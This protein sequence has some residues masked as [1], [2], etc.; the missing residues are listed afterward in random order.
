[1]GPMAFLKL[2]RLHG[3]RRELLAADPNTTTITELAARRCL[4]G[5]LS[6]RGAAP[7]TFEVYTNLMVTGY[8]T[9][10]RKASSADL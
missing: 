2:R 9:G 3:V 7:S 6:A 1:M 10:N 5:K 8:A 4:S